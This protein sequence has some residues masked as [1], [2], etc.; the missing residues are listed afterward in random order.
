MNGEISLGGHALFTERFFKMVEISSG[1]TVGRGI[2]TGGG[3]DT[4]FGVKLLEWEKSE[5]K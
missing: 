5:Q 4:A 2:D 1:V 3:E